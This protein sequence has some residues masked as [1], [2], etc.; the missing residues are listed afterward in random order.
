MMAVF[1]H[2][3]CPRFRTRWLPDRL[4]NHHQD[5]QAVFQG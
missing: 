2:Q 1:H 5:L 4:V 3:M